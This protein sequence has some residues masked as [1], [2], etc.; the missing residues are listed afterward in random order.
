MLNNS[1]PQSTSGIFNQTLIW[2]SVLATLVISVGSIWTFHSMNKLIKATQIQKEIALGKG[3]AISI[4]DLIVTRDYAQIESDLRQVMSNN[5]VRSIVIADLQGNVLAFL[6]RDSQQEVVHS[7]FIHNIIDLPKNFS[8]DFSFSNI[9]DAS[10]LW[11]QINPGIPLGWIRMES[12]DGLT[13]VL[14]S[15]LRINL[16]VSMLM[17]LLSLSS[18]AIGFLYRLKHTSIKNELKLQKNNRSLHLAAHIDALTKLPNRLALNKL[19]DDATNKAKC[20]NDHLAICFLD[21]DKFKSVNDLL[22]HSSGDSLLIAAAGRMLTAVRTNDSIIRYGGDEFVLL[23]GG[24]KDIKE[25]DALLSRILK[26]LS[27]PFMINGRSVQVSA[28][29]GTSIYPTDGLTM[30]DLLAQADKAMYE[31]KANGRNS[32][33]LYKK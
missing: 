11:Y 32:W 31:T 30:K 15:N 24:I 3:L 17:L 19:F 14:L 25:L 33:L 13:D 18:G 9:G 22:G 20:R 5:A 7:N 1:L 2:F 8:G 21:L 27:S 10:V 16:I 28:S 26:L 23:L 29:I 6:E 12:F 4:G